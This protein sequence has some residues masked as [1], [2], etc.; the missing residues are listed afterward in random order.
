ML[1]NI[2]NINKVLHPTDLQ[3]SPSDSFTLASG[4][5]CID[6]D[7]N[8]TCLDE[9]NIPVEGISDD[10]NEFEIEF[11]NQVDSNA[12]HKAEMAMLYKAQAQPLVKGKPQKTAKPFILQDISPISSLMNIKLLNVVSHIVLNWLKSLA[13][14]D[15]SSLYDYTNDISAS[16]RQHSSCPNPKS[17]YNIGL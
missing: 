16:Q 10:D 3:S 4:L 15:T 17:C 14:L 2:E 8:N 12:N 11:C 9:T 7:V 1:C 13:N 5:D 6:L